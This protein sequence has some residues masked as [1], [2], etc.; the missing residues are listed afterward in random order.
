MTSIDLKKSYRDHYTAKPEPTIVQVPERPHLMIDGEGDPN[1]SPAYRDAV[2]ALYPL[3]YGLRSAIKD[4][5]GVAYTVMPLEGLW[6]VEGGFSALDDRSQWRW[7]AMICQPDEATGELAQR[8]LPKVTTAK[9]LAAGG[10][11]R[12]ERFGDG[13]A[14]QILHLGPYSQEGPTIDR[15]HRFV[16]GNGYRLTGKHHEIYLTDPRKGDPDK[17]RTIIRQPVTEN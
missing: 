15:L 6:W 5:T 8:V 3:A 11:A 16:E 14:A 17:T 9:K 2:A 7:T 4:S 12:L 13:L 1:T 10:L